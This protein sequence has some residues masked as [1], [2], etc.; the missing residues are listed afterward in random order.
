MAEAEGFD[1]NLLKDFD[2]KNLPGFDEN[3]MKM[4]EAEG[5]DPKL[6][7]KFDPNVDYA[8]LMK[9]MEPKMPEGFDPNVDY[10]SLMKDL[11]E[12]FDPNVDYASLMKGMPGGFDGAAAADIDPHA[13]VDPRLMAEGFDPKLLNGLKKKYKSKPENSLPNHQISSKFAFNFS[14]N[15]LILY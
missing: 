13:G 3:L 12:G 11:P 15:V 6:L 10:A 7:E 2:P 5:L 1:P 14:T 4:A 9:E 8:A